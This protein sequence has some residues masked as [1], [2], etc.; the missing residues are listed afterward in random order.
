MPITAQDAKTI[1]EAEKDSLLYLIIKAFDK[2]GPRAGKF[3]VKSL[4]RMIQIGGRTLFGVRIME[5]TS[6]GFC[7]GSSAV[8]PL[9]VTMTV[10]AGGPIF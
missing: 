1:Y 6:T 3:S 8:I 10:A 9:E 5:K 2:K 4:T 7:C